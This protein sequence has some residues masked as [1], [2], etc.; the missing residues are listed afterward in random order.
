M[1]ITNR[2]R[3]DAVL[4]KLER[5]ERE[6]YECKQ[7]LRHIGRQALVERDMEEAQGGTQS[8]AVLE[9]QYEYGP[10]GTGDREGLY[11][12]QLDYQYTDRPNYKF[13][14]DEET[15]CDT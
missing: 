10:T 5:T 9:D 13:E 14:E 1:A 11:E 12:G 3:L 15:A 8:T 2:H 6:L 4:S 7:I